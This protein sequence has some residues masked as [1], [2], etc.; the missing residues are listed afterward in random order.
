MTVA[1]LR[2]RVHRRYPQFSNPIQIRPSPKARS[3]KQLASQEGL[4]GRRSSVCARLGA[5]TTEATTVYGGEDV[6]SIRPKTT[7]SQ[8]SSNPVKPHSRLSYRPVTIPHTNQI[9]TNHQSALARPESSKSQN[10][11]IRDGLTRVEREFV[12]IVL[13]TE[14]GERVRI[15]IE[16]VHE[17]LRSGKSSNGTG[18]RDS[19][20]SL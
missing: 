2:G 17:P 16:I 5:S 18:I 12:V 3:R 6:T 9:S 10:W 11:A 20:H 4:W 1:R 14:V 13:E 7:K 19:R 15:R 8:F